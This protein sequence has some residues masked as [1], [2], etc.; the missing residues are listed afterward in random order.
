MKKIIQLLQAH[1]IEVFHA[2][3]KEIIHGDKNQEIIINHWDMDETL[4]YLG[5][6]PLNPEF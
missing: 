2:Q 4:D 1:G 5:Y 6:D 3:D